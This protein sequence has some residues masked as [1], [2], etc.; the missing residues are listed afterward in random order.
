MCLLFKLQT[1]EVNLEITKLI[2][3]ALNGDCSPAELEQL[4]AWRAAAIENEMEYLQYVSIWEDSLSGYQE[5]PALTAEQSW[6]SFSARIKRQPPSQSAVKHWIYRPYYLVRIAA[7]VTILII[8]GIY[9]SRDTAFKGEFQTTHADRLVT[10]PDGSLVHLASES[11]IKAMPLQNGKIRMVNL[12]GQ[13][14]FEVA[15]DQEK[16]FIVVAGDLT[17]EVVGTDFY[18]AYL[19]GSVK[20]IVEVNHGKV[21]LKVPGNSNSVLLEA[22]DRAEW[23]ERNGELLLPKVIDRNNWLWHT[24]ELLFS[25]SSLSEVIQVFNDQY[26]AD[27]KIMNKDLRDCQ[28]TGRI[29][30]KTVSEALEILAISFNFEVKHSQHRQYT[31]VG[32]SCK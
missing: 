7:A 5:Q 21:K 32:G 24:G 20:K 14:H 31:L 19:P 12:E 28:Y 16:P 18:V 4:N 25:K 27:I 22:G 23:Y 17:V 11:Y 30:S 3:K 29:K 26:N 15:S 1:P 10:L 13:A 6:R 9:L 2:A 8:A